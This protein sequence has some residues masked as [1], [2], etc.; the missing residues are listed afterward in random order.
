MEGR[1]GGA[2]VCICGHG[3]GGCGACQMLREIRDFIAYAAAA[4]MHK[5]DRDW[6]EAMRTIV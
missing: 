4:K 3:C 2:A 5:Q 1:A 6:I